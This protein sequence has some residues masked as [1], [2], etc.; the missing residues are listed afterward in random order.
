MTRVPKQAENSI[1]EE[2]DKERGHKYYKRLDYLLL[3]E[4]SRCFAADPGQSITLKER[5]E[6]LYFFYVISTFSLK[7]IT[8]D[9]NGSFSTLINE[10]CLE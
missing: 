9:D 3:I 8:C 5:T 2:T 4:Y 10:Y 6:Q 1:E 7:V